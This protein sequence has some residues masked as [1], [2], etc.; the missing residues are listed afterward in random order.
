VAT[1]VS[2]LFTRNWTL[3]LA[4]LG[5]ALLLWSVVKAEAP[6][7]ITIPDVP[8]EVALRDA[9]WAPAAPPAPSTVNVVFSGPVRDLLRLA[10]ERPR[11]VVPVE[12]VRD[13]TEVHLLQPRWVQVGRDGDRV[14]AEDIRPST[15]RLSF[16]RVTTRLLP[17]IASTRGEPLAGYRLDGPIRA[18]PPAITVS[19]PASRLAGLEV[20]RLPSVDISMFTGPT[21]ITVSVDTTAL[22]GLAVTPDQVTL[23]V[24]IV[25]VPRDTAADSVTSESAG[26][27]RWRGE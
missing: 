22:A 1:R 3:K 26:I 24:P 9:R 16:E 27:V 11:I 4:A 15:V 7:R 19:G 8:V 10:A 20:V 14:G 13:S 23:T 6:V 18:D 17:V 12:E 2:E 25:P 5:L 21:A